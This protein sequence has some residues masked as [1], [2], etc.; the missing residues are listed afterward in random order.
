[1]N[2]QYCLL[3]FGCPQN[4][5]HNTTWCSNWLNCI[6][7]IFSE[8]TDG[9]TYGMDPEI[10]CNSKSE[11]HFHVFF[12][13]LHHQ[14]NWVRFTLVYSLLTCPHV[15]FVP[16]LTLT[17]KLLTGHQTDLD[18]WTWQK[19]SQNSILS[20]VWPYLHQLYICKRQF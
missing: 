8:D 13:C 4:I 18:K 10:C 2:F 11:Y 9:N 19:F 12:S 6:W 1:M 3:N 14:K 15:I 5:I 20:L 17:F 7:F 16:K